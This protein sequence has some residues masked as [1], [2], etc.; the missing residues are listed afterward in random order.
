M[1]TP[2]EF[3]DALAPDYHLLFD[4][5]WSAAQWHGG[6]I[7][8]LLEGQG[9]TKGRLL[10]CTCGIGTQALSL[11]ALG[12]EVTGTD[13]SGAL[14]D[15]ARVEASARGLDLELAVRDVRDLIDGVFDVVI[16]FDN[17]LPHLLSDEEL[18]RAL[19]RIHRCLEPGGLLMASIRDYDLLRRTRP[20][21]MPISVHGRPGSRHGSGQAWQWSPDAEFVDLELFT[22]T[23]AATGKWHARSHTTR[24]RA[25]QRGTLD[26]LL[27]SVG[28][29]STEWLMPDLSGYYQPIVVAKA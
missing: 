24:Y 16:S 3:Y 5:W 19:A 27:R 12:Y 2:A 21:G 18:E 10:D 20:E 4:D 11:A 14:I 29:T 22:F 25:L 17:A 28:F 1:D 9:I 15:R 7:A 6:V 26:R 8:D 23:E 13:V